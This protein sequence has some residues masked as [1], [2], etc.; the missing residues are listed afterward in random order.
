[1]GGGARG[2]TLA[3]LSLNKPVEERL[4]GRVKALD[5][6]WQLMAER[7]DE[8]GQD[9][10]L[11]FEV[12]PN[13]RLKLNVD[14]LGALGESASLKWLRRTT[15]KMHPKIDLPDLLFEVDSWTGFLDAFVHLGDGRTRM[16]DIKTSLVALLVSEACNIGYTPVID[17][18]DEALT[19]ARLVHVDQYYL[20]VDTIAAVN[21]KLIEAQARVPIVKF[22]GE[23]L[24]ASVDGLRFVVPKRTVNAGPSPKYYHFK[25]GITWLNAV[26]DQVAGI[27]QMVVPGTPRDSLHIL[28]ALLN[29]DAGVKPEM[30][31]TDNASYSDMVFGL[32]T[33]LG[34]NF[35]PALQGPERPAVLAG[36]DA[37]RRDRRLRTAGGPGPQQ[38][39]PEQGHHA[40]AGHAAGGPLSGD[41]AGPRVR[42]AA[43]VRP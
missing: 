12:Q 36:G 4:K 35:S 29:L 19:R 2:H 11:S 28:D 40:L 38:G 34:Y 23:G 8:A 21:A 1:M 27:G 24:L 18:E 22:W 31:A 32:F 30:V 26:N 39:E 20:R 7:L 41:R 9:A 43:D 13:G 42:P 6:A 33:M 3:G 17:A 5:A 10:K 14:R 16:E 15:A 25:R 37:R